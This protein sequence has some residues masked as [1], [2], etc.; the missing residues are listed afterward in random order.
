MC[1]EEIC[2]VQMELIPFL[3]L[4]LA[5]SCPRSFLP[6]P[7]L[8]PACLPF[9]GCLRPQETWGRVGAPTWH[10]GELAVVFCS[11]AASQGD[12]G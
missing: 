6:V 7:C 8:S 3:R 12:P 9:E 10:A 2:I 1:V 11:H 4:A 5:G